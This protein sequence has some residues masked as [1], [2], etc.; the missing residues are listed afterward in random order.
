MTLAAT[1]SKADQS[2]MLDGVY[3]DELLGVAGTSWPIGTPDR[4]VDNLADA[5]LI[6]AAR[7]YQK[8]YLAGTGA[9]AITLTDTFEA[10]VV[11]NP[12]YSISI[13]AGATV[14]ILGD[15]DCYEILGTSGDLVIIGNCRASAISTETG[16][17]E[18]YGNCETRGGL[19]V[20]GT[21]TI[22]IYGNLSG[23]PTVYLSHAD[24]TISVYG[25]VSCYELVATAGYGFYCQAFYCQT[26]ADFSALTE[27]YINDD[28][29]VVGTITNPDADFLVAGKLKAS[30]FI[31]GNGALTTYD[32]CNISSLFTSNGTGVIIIG[33]DAFIYEVSNDNS[34]EIY[35][36][37]N[38]VIPGD[39]SNNNIGSI[40][41]VAGIGYV[42]G[43]ITDIGSMTWNSAPLSFSNDYEIDINAINAGETSVVEFVGTDNWRVDI[44]KL[45]IKCADPGANTVTVKLYENRPEGY[46]EIDSFEITTLNYATYFSLMDI[47]GIPEI[48]GQYIK[49]TVQASAGGP[50]RVTGLMTYGYTRIPDSTP[51][52][53]LA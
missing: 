19:G 8:L 13:A 33:K 9:H 1:L 15:F 12:E 26:D 49:I 5:L 51:P 20:T 34:G 35:V 30:N 27:V 39:L 45:R 21:G 32:D 3:F 42:W 44:Q 38:C 40:F 50:Y 24:A 18:I 16:Q 41:S 25:K 17:I 46:T 11:G 14:Q 43:T 36:L 29:F 52:V 48:S 22:N 31:N 28:C 23:N 47:F 10:I 4:A 37:G 6:M 2:K 7:N 53:H